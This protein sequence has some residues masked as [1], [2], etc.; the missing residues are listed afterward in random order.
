MNL[1]MTTGIDLVMADRMLQMRTISPADV[2]AIDGLDGTRI[3]VIGGTHGIGRSIADEAAATR[4]TGRRG[5]S[6]HRPRR[7]RC[8]RRGRP[9]RGGSGA[10]RR[11]GP[12]RGDGRH[13][14]PRAVGGH[15][16]RGSRRG[17]RRQPHGHDERR[18]GGVPPSRDDPGLVHR[19]RLELVHPGPT[20]LRGVF[21]EQGRGR[22]PGAGSRRGVGGLRRPGERRQSR[23]DRH[24]DASR[25]RSR[26]NRGRGS[27]RPAMSP[28]P[29]CG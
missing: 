20:G 28:T 18:R 24:A 27:W 13:P 3:L 14:P 25:T 23:A 26:T 10:P 8:G 12:C 5:G 22:Q 17:H 9:G 19:V 6:F 29:P 15:A 4:R 7:P 1:K 21:G 11:P 2:P 16:R